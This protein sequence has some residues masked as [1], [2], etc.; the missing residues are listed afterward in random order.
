MLVKGETLKAREV[1]SIIITEEKAA[2]PVLEMV[3]IAQMP[4][5]LPL[6]DN[7]FV[8]FE[9]APISETNADLRFTRP[10]VRISS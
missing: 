1:R 8:Q 6:N 2:C 3:T 5:H 4:E 10:G 9:E 7:S